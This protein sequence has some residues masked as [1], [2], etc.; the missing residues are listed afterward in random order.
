MLQHPLRRWPIIETTL[1]E[2]YIFAGLLDHEADNFLV[3]S[4]GTNCQCFLF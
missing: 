4:Q 3:P 2:R 1:G